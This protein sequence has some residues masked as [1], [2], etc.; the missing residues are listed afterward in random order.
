[1][2]IQGRKR[3]EREKECRFLMLD[4]QFLTASAAPDDA[5]VVDLVERLVRGCTNS[6]KGVSGRD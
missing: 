4:T 2:G 6:P 1:M 3:E 5:P